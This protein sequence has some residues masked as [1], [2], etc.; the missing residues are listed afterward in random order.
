MC[1]IRKLLRN[2]S[3]VNGLISE[4]QKSV[5]M[6]RGENKISPFSFILANSFSELTIKKVKILMDLAQTTPDGKDL[7][8]A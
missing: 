8:W 3:A 7:R 4:K 2:T 6:P 5:Q 1:N